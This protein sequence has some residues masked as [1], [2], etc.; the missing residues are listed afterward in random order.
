[1]ETLE[2]KGG[3]LQELFMGQDGAR[4]YQAGLPG[5]P[6]NFPRDS[7]ISG[8]LMRDAELLRDQL[9]FCA[10]RQGK[11]RNPLNG[12]ERGKIFHE[13]PGFKIRE[14]STEYNA[15]DTTALYLFGHEVYQRLTQDKSL[16]ED[17]EENLREAV[18]YILSHL[19]EEGGFIEDPRFAG[20]QRFALK[21]TYWKDSELLGRENGEAHYP[22]VYSVAHAQNLR[23][24]RSAKFLLGE[25]SLEEKIG[26][27][28]DYFVNHL[29]DPQ[30]HEIYLARD[31]VGPIKAV[32]SDSLHILFYLE[33]G[34]VPSQTLERIAK[35][36]RLIETD[37]GFRTMAAAEAEEVGDVYHTKTIWPFEQALIHIGARRFGLDGASEIAYRVMQHLDSDNEIFVIRDGVVEKG[38]NDPQLWTYAA[39]EYFGNLDGGANE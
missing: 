7:I 24:L 28:K 22:V 30:T 38:G 25:N 6:R 26:K 37:F 31:S 1:M 32:S 34:D 21:V 29:I 27:M 35:D 9:I 12:E 5:F 33:N 19:N 15:C 10:K 36:S 23:G 16:A 17:Q 11:E 3:V 14:L 2:L 20:A 18:N 13:Y 4:L 8:I 39:K